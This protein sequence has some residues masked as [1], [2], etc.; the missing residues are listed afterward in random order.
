MPSFQA[1]SARCAPNNYARF[2][3][4]VARS[5]DVDSSSDGGEESRS[6]GSS[7]SLQLAAAACCESLAAALPLQQFPNQYVDTRG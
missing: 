6:F 4:I 1:L 7:Q 2:V 5:S 3:V